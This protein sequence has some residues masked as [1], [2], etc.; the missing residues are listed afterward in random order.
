MSSSSTRG[1]Y[2]VLWHGNIYGRDDLWPKHL[3][4]SS[5][6]YILLLTL[7]TANSSLVG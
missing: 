3:L 4:L 1:I 5:A 7:S 2:M 6:I